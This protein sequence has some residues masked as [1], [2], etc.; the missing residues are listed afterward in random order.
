MK[1]YK[2]LNGLKDEQKVNVGTI[3]E[4]TINQQLTL[5]QYNFVCSG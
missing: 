4:S 1:K 3:I 5:G 2:F